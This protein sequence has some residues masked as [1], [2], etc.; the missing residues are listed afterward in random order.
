VFPW[1]FS[2]I[3]KVGVRVFFH[4]VR[5]E[6]TRM[7]VDGGEVELETSLHL[8]ALGWTFDKF[9]EGHDQSE[10]R[11]HIFISHTGLKQARYNYGKDHHFELFLH[12]P[13]SMLPILQQGTEERLLELQAYMDQVDDTRIFDGGEVNPLFIESTNI[14]R[15]SIEEWI[16]TRSK[17]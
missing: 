15:A 1:K 9:P 14:S 17:G 2:G 4:S 13:R 11:L 6:R 7:N 8:E 16:E 3:T 5:P 10:G 12:F